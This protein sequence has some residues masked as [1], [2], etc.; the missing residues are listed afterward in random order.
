VSDQG[1]IGETE[2]RLQVVLGK[3]QPLKVCSWRRSDCMI[4]SDSFRLS[5]GVQSSRLRVRGTNKVKYRRR[6]GKLINLRK[7]QV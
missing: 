7:L 6:R 1:F 3:R 4:R 2:V 5:E